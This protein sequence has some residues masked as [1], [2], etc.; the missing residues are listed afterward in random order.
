MGGAS[1]LIEKPVNPHPIPATPFSPPP[2]GLDSPHSPQQTVKLS[3]IKTIIGWTQLSLSRT[4]RLKGSADLIALQISIGTLQSIHCEELEVATH[5]YRYWMYR[6][7]VYVLSCVQMPARQ[8]VSRS[9]HPLFCPHCN[10]ALQGNIE[11][12]YVQKPVSQ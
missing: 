1:T 7:V 4:H 9:I 10:F 6:W 3:R 8:S 12:V 2:Q 11:G 5:G